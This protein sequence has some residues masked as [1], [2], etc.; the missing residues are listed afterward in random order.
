[1]KRTQ[2][3]QRRRAKRKRRVRGHVTGSSE[4]PRL[5]V[6]KSNK[7]LYVQAVDDVAGVT[8]AAVSSLA[9]ETKGLRPTVADGER[10]GEAIG[11]AL[12]DRNVTEAVFDRNGHLYHGV[13]RSVAEG[14]RKT[15]LRL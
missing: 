12:K 13:V 14:A 7:H 2:E 8:L 6:F 15:G 4:R 9:G 10:I 11:R 5:T 1:M 3:K